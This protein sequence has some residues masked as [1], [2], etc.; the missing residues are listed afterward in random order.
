MKGEYEMPQ[1]VYGAM[2]RHIERE[3]MQGKKRQESACVWCD[4]RCDYRLCVV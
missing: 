3:K 1:L 2:R 4:Y